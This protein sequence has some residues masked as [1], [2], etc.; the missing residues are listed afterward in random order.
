MIFITS[1]FAVSINLQCQNL[2]AYISD[3][4]HFLKKEK[5]EKNVFLDVHWNPL[6]E[7]K[8][9]RKTSKK[10]TS[11]K[12]FWPESFADKKLLSYS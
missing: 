12:Q 11:K 6:G 9:L 10:I 4:K 1:F 5:I 2:K 3:G 8:K 7:E